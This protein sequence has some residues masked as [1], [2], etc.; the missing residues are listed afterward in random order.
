M[1]I[2]GVVTHR[3]LW[4][5][6]RW[7]IVLSFVIAALLTPGPDVISQVLMALPMILLYNGS[8]GLAYLVARRR[9]AAARSPGD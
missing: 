6:N 9:A 8:I 4:R 5:F 3:S 7:F 2:A 1:S